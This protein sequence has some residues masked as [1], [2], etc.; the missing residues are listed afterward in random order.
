M[1]KLATLAGISTMLPGTDSGTQTSNVSSKSEKLLCFFPKRHASFS[2]GPPAASSLLGAGGLHASEDNLFFVS[3]ISVLYVLVSLIRNTLS[4]IDKHLN[5]S[6]YFNLS[7]FGRFDDN[8]I[9][10][11]LILPILC[12]KTHHGVGKFL[13]F[14]RKPCIVAKL[15][16]PI[17]F[18]N[19]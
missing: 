3:V 4:L 9:N 5:E 12:E 13:M 14:Y 16:K 6:L 18:L 1:F 7:G 15:V 10:F 17:Q 19:L 2:H 11:N 8:S